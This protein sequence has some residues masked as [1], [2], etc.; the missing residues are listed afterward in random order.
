[1]Y[2]SSHENLARKKTLDEINHLRLGEF[3]LVIS[4]YFFTYEINK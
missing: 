1:M 2:D 3:F 4:D